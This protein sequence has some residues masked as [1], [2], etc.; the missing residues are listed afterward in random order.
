MLRVHKG[1]MT[2]A[3]FVKVLLPCCPNWIGEA[4]Q[5]ANEQDG[6]GVLHI[7]LSRQCRVYSSI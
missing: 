2:N 1:G 6:I 4:M 7:S 5:S 3:F